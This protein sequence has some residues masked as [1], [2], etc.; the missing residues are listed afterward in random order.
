MNTV[1][2]FLDGSVVYGSD[3]KVTA[4]LRSKVGGKLRVEKKWSCKRGFL[5]EVDDKLSV[6]DLTNT[7]EP[8]YMSGIFF[9]N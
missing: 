6:C 5:P 3:P 2:G 7:S 1:T 4:K 8:C 9:L